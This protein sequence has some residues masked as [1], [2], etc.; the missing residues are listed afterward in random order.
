MVEILLKITFLS[1]RDKTPAVQINSAIGN[2]KW[3]RLKE[4]WNWRP[5]K[6]E[7]IY[8]GSAP[9]SYN[10]KFHLMHRL[11]S[12]RGDSEPFFS[13]MPCNSGLFVEQIDKQRAFSAPWKTHKSD[14]S[15]ETYITST[16]GRDINASGK[17]W[18]QMAVYVKT[19]FVQFHTCVSKLFD[20]FFKNILRSF[21]SSFQWKKSPYINENVITMKHF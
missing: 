6:N 13:F 20:P 2:N 17:L 14:N 4:I 5:A 8:T 9:L 18:F 21:S 3:R 7:T 1:K 15:T 11:Q 16:S 12:L 19:I 10:L